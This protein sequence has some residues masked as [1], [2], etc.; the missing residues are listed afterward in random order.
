MAIN[1]ASCF[2]AKNFKRSE[3]RLESLNN[4]A[5]SSQSDNSF[6][7]GNVHLIRFESY[8]RS[9]WQWNYLF[10]RLRID[11]KLVHEPLEFSN[12]LSLCTRFL[13]FGFRSLFQTWKKIE[14]KTNLIFFEFEL[15][16]YCLCSLQKSISKSN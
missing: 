9:R 7:I 8:H 6:K 10:I 15:D 1:K 12:A 16:F 4:S 13:N 11:S 3:F 5:V 2:L 14:F